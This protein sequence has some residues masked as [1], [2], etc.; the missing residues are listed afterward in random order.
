M[1]E[2]KVES[3]ERGQHGK[4]LNYMMDGEPMLLELA[5]ALLREDYLG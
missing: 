5:L 2:L 4:V 1:N 3:A